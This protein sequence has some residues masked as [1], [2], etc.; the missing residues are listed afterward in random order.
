MEV[1]FFGT[2][3]LKFLLLQRG[4]ELLEITKADAIQH[5]TREPRD[6]LYMW[7]LDHFRRE[8]S[9]HLGGYSFTLP[10]ILAATRVIELINGD[11]DRDML[12][13]EITQQID[14]FKA[15]VKEF[16]GESK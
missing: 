9:I 11:L 3:E 7:A 13:Y 14:I 10:V 1:V 8:V 15:A 12:D 16:K 5:R 6:I 4:Y 2:A